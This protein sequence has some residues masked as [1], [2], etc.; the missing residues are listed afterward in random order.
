MS[1]P[2]CAIFRSVPPRI[3]HNGWPSMLVRN[4]SLTV[5]PPNIRKWLLRPA[6]YDSFWLSRKKRVFIFYVTSTCEWFILTFSVIAIHHPRLVQLGPVSNKPKK[7]RKIISQ[8]KQ[9]QNNTGWPIEHTFWD[10]K[11]RN[12]GIEFMRSNMPEGCVSN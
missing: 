12:H 5:P 6:K 2:L 10:K 1:Q 8:I 7:N 3:E 9:R 4:W 11:S